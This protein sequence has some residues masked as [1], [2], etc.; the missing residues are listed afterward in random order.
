MV[1]IIVYRIA[2][3]V[4][5]NWILANTNFKMGIDLNGS[6]RH[7]LEVKALDIFFNEVDFNANHV[8]NRTV[9]VIYKKQKEEVC[10]LEVEAVENIVLV[11]YLSII[12]VPSV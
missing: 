6:V 4:N 12:L 5:R 10:L 7:T 8:R 3:V 2:V 11:I 1:E 9:L